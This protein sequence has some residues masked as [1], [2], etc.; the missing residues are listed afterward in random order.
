V[1]LVSGVSTFSDLT[2]NNVGTGYTLKA[3]TSGLSTVT[4]TA[5]DIIP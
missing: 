1:V 2:V 5:F 3:A 4:S